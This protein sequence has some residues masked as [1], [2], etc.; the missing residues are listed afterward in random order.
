[1][2]I[3]NRP[4]FRDEEAAFAFLEGIVWKSGTE[5]PHCGVVG[6]AYRIKANPAKRVRFGLWK[7]KDYRKQFTVKVGTVLEHAR[8]AFMG[9]RDA[10]P[11]VALFAQVSPKPRKTERERH[12]SVQ[13]S[14]GIT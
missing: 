6:T 1:M 14:S 11:R 10:R 7:C 9:R 13:R 8:L 4:Y 12:R 5:C 2:S 3:L